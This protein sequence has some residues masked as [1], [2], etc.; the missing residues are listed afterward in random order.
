MAKYQQYAEYKDSGVEWLGEIPKDWGVT[1]LKFVA[2]IVGRIGF[3]GYTV[4]DIVN[5]G[6]GAIVLSPS[7]VHDDQFSLEKK[8]YLSWAKYFESPEIMVEENDILL[9]KT[10]STFGK[11]T[12]VREVGE[13]MTINPQMVL[14]KKSSIDSRFLSYLFNSSLIKAKIEVS[15]T[16]SGMPTMTQENI[17]NFPIPLPA[18]KIDIKIANFLDHETAQIDTLIEKQQTLIQLLK[19]K[20]QAV[21]SHAV[22]KGLNPDAP[23]K[24]SGVEWLGEVP[25]GWKVAT[26]RRYLLEHRQGYYTSDSYVDD[27]TKLLRI[28]DLRDLGK[29]DTNDSPKVPKSASLNNYLLKEGDV[30]FARTGGAGSFGV[31]PEVKEDIAYASYLIRFRF[32]PKFFN[33]NYLRFM[34]IADSFQLAVKQNIHGGVNQNIHAEDI[35]NTFVASPPLDEQEKISTYL[36][37]QTNSYAKLIANAE[38]AIQLMQERRTALISAAVTGK[39]DVRGWRASE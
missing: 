33:T 10:G 11:S 17:N 13:P 16:G 1:H 4:D 21:I 20:R 30:V 36:D 23:M 12:I 38:Q 24:D 8:S 39:I 9:V 3:R 29:I 35:K 6:Q 14:I 26:V 7:N 2:S 19:E 18:T 28:T 32:L 31:I 34:F 25:Q 27:G 15:N 5:E 22:T 37:I